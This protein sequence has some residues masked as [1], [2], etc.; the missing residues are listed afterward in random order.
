MCFVWIWE[1]T[2]IISL[3]NINWLVFITEARRVF[4]AVRTDLF[5]YNSGYVL[6]SQAV[7][8]F[9]QSFKIPSPRRPRFDLRSVHVR[10]VVD[11]VTWDRFLC[12]YFDFPPSLSFHQCSTLTFI[13]MLLLPK[14]QTAEAWEPSQSNALS[15]VE[16]LWLQECSVFLM[17]TPCFM[18]RRHWIVKH[19]LDRR[20]ALLRVTTGAVLL[21][22]CDCTSLGS[23]T[24]D[25]A[26]ED[27]HATK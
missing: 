13:C 2:A 14:G 18:L 20:L 3:Y 19:C 11:K 16:E 24:L 7:T 5:K 6:S 9:K 15:D 4:C 8:W 10:F 21:D 1:Q 26:A 27:G 23:G 12:Q 17:E 25:P 22:T